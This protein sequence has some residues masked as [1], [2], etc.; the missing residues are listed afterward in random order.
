MRVHHIPEGFIDETVMGKTDGKK[1]KKHKMKKKKD[2]MDKG[3]KKDKKNKK[4]HY[5]EL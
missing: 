2:K 1:K 5:D 4:K 3:V